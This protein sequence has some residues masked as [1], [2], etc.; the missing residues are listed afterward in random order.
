MN[1]YPVENNAP[2]FPIR[3]FDPVRDF[4]TVDP[5]DTDDGNNGLQN[6]PTLESAKEKPADI[7][8]RQSFGPER[9]I[10][11]TGLLDSTPNSRFLL[12]FFPTDDINSTITGVLNA[13][14]ID[15]Q[16]TLIVETSAAGL[17][18]FTHVVTGF[19]ADATLDHLTA[20]AT[21][22]KPRVNGGFDFETSEFAE[23]IKI[24][25]DTD[26]DADGAGRHG[27]SAC[28]LGR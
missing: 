18:P 10:V 22:V 19:L 5:R 17:A 15:R 6:F 12:E 16:N 11:V 28:G 9:Q 1:S 4:T 14:N 20:T 27:R 2:K 23:P 8:I 25:P 3:L 21:R 7:S 13:R 26:A 24:T